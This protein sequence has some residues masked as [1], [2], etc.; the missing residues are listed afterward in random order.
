MRIS[1]PDCTQG[2]TASPIWT[3]GQRHRR[4]PAPDRH[5][6]QT[7]TSRR[8]GS[9]VEISRRKDSASCQ[10]PIHDL[11]SGTYCLWHSR[12]RMAIERGDRQYNLP[13]WALLRSL[14]SG[15]VISDAV[16]TVYEGSSC[17]RYRGFRAVPAHRA[18]LGDDD[19]FK[20]LARCLFRQGYPSPPL[21]AVIRH[22]R[23][24]RAIDYLRQ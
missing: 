12:L 19:L 20:M 4:P 7:H 10:S 24:G 3:S 9:F 21:R 23:S 6:M 2:F 8:P 18:I 14:T 13:A 11:S 15:E 22:T 5:L 16:A 17:K 1:A